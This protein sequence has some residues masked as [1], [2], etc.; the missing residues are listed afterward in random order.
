MDSTKNFGLYMDKALKTIKLNYLK[1]FK[2]LG[3]NFTPEQWV[4]LDILYKEDGVSQTEL[5]IGSFKDSPT[6]S[7]IIDLLEKKELVTRM[8]FENDRRRYKIFLTEKG[9]TDYDIALPAVNELREKSWENL[10][11]EDYKTYLRIMSQ[12]VK[13]FDDE[14]ALRH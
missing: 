3:L 13:N 8:R 2:E 7:R 4:I 11:E 14:K 9:Q 1:A 12:I 5:A 6:V 10:S